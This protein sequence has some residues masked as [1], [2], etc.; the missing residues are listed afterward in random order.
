MSYLF[1]VKAT[2]WNAEGDTSIDR[3]LICYTNN[4]DQIKKGLKFFERN[5][6]SI[7]VDGKVLKGQLVHDLRTLKQRKAG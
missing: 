5:A 3:V 2:L 4:K 7:M 1:E 6:E